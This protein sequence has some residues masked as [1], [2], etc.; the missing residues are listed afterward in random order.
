MEL[1]SFA[2]LVEEVGGKVRGVILEISRFVV[3]VE[4]LGGL[5]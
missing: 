2:I 4:V 1:K 3:W 5:L